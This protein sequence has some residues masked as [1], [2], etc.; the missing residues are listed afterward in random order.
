MLGHIR[1]VPWQSQMRLQIERDA[2]ASGLLKNGKGN[3]VM[4]CEA[5]LHRHQEA[6]A[7]HG[8]ALANSIDIFTV[9]SIPLSSGPDLLS[10]S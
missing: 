9:Q 5:F 8:E 3:A 4:L 7:S 2:S 10:P 6:S 1:W